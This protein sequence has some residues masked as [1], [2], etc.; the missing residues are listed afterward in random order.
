MYA[1]GI[2]FTLES[3]L[4]SGINGINSIEGFLI[5]ILDAFVIIAIP[6][7]ILF[8]IYAGFLYV[9]ARGNVE[10]V[11]QATRSLTYA[12]IGGVLVIGAA[13]ISV[14]VKNVVDTFAA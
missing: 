5:A 6:I 4:K 9:T 10:Q 3:K 8:I 14:V 1:A 11:Q 12:I 2:N 7:L 13:A